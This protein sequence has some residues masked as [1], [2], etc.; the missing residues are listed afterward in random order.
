EHAFTVA[1]E[2]DTVFTGVDPLLG[3][4]PAEGEVDESE[5]EVGE[6]LIEVGDEVSYRYGDG[7]DD[8]GGADV[9]RAVIRLERV[10]ESHEGALPRCV[11]A[12]GDLDVA[13]IDGLLAPLRLTTS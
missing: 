5:V 9:V 3:S 1:D 8:A 2:P 13:A 4:E 6:L 11:G 10:Q 12:S 7:A